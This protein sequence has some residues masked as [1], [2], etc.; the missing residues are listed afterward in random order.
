MRRDCEWSSRWKHSCVGIC[1]G[2]GGP[3][4]LRAGAV[5]SVQARS[6]INLI[7]DKS[8]ES[9]WP[10]ES[11]DYRFKFGHVYHVYLVARL[12]GFG[13]VATGR[14]RSNLRFHNSISAQGL[15]A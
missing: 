11:N 6:S 9:G 4:L 8:Y 5:F 10:I 7:D 13:Q 1:P 15:M 2:L 12:S 3:N 14:L